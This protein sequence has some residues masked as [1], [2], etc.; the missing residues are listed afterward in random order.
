MAL[1]RTLLA[2]V[3]LA[4]ARELLQEGEARREAERRL[5]LHTEAE[6]LASEARLRSYFEAAPQSILAVSA[7]GEIRLVNRKTE[8]MFGY[9][10]EQLL[11]QPIELLL[12]ESL[13][14]TYIEHRKRFRNGT[15]ARNAAQAQGLVLAGRRKN[16]TEF[17]AEVGLG[18]VETPEG[19]LALGLVSDITERKRAADELA[20]VN[21]ELRRSNA[22]LE[23]FAYVASHDLQEP[24]RMV[25]G[26]LQLLERRYQGQLD[27]DAQ[28]FIRF[29]V[30]GATRM[31][32]LIE[33]LL[34]FSRAG[35]QNVSFRKVAGAALLH[36]ALANLSAAIQECSARIV[37][38]P[39]PELLGD[40]GLLTQVLQNLIG[41][42]VKFRR[43]GQPRIHVGATWQGN[44]WVLAVR[45]D[46]IGMDSAHLDRIFRIFE[47]LHTAD[48]YPGTG[49]GLAIA[50]RIIERHGGRIWVESSPGAGSTF[51]F[52]LPTEPEARQ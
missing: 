44:E 29:A 26:Y 46:G 34:R 22:E 32:S 1:L 38:D 43:L 14:V 37:S 3:G 45:D 41:N 25:T 10:R 19:G 18:F 42:A 39:L 47:R 48:R 2:S 33:D 21:Q 40:P 17:P 7:T 36:D 49:V 31:K 5:T 28:E 16:G 24:L 9:S 23:Q 11:G 12:P 51:Y 27:A 13:P 4:P 6:R 8:E 30:D 50:K 52:S 15:R 35:T 20:R